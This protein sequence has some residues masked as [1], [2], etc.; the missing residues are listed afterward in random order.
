MHR[1]PWAWL[2]WLVVLGAVS[3]PYWQPRAPALLC[4]S[5]ALCGIAAIGHRA[6]P[7]WLALAVAGFLL[8]AA[9]PAMLPPPITGEHLQGEIISVSNRRTVLRTDNGEAELWFSDTVPPVGS[10]VAVWTASATPW[11]VLPGA[12]DST[13]ALRRA[14]RHRMRAR[15]WMLLGTPTASSN[16]QRTAAWFQHVRHGALLWALIRGKREDIPMETVELLRRTGTAHL[17]AISGMHIGWVSGLAWW[18]AWLLS[19]PL[20]L[21]RWAKPGQFVPILAGTAA[22]WMYGQAVGWPISTQRAVW[23][24]TALA[25]ARLLGRRVSLWNVLGMTAAGIALADPAQVGEIGFWMSFGAVA[26]MLSWSHALTRWLPPDHPGWLGRLLLGMAASLGATLGTLPMTAWLF[27]QL[28]PLTLFTNLI[29]GPL[30]AGVALP[31]ALLSCALPDTPARLALAVADAATQLTMTAL[32]AMDVDPLHP[33]VGPVGAMALAAVL[34]LR[35]HPGI[36]GLLLLLALGLRSHPRQLSVTFLAIGQ[37][38]AALVEWPDGT[39]WL[40]DGG[41]PS[42]RLLH[43]L[44][45]RGIRSLDAIILSHPHPDHMGGLQPIVDAMP[46][47][48]LWV[49]RPPMPG[50]TQFRQLW[51]SAFAQ[52][53]TIR[54][55][56]DH[57]LLSRGELLHPLNGWTAQRRQDRVNEE[58]LVVQIT[59]GAHRFLFT[60][61][62][63][64]EAETLLVETLETVDVIKVPH[65]G[66]TSSSSEA[67][68]AATQAKWAVISCGERNRFR[69]PRPRTLHRWRDAQVLRTDTNGTIRFRSD[70]QTLTVESHL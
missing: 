39:R 6:R 45:R 55:P 1:F 25:G 56:V 20:T 23:M 67:L 5:A 17:L 35:R 52:H 50:E 58:S 28:S 4:G 31:A 3:W 70:G 69:H 64:A 63:E 21:L 48:E 18:T 65:H 54:T 10:R 42:S 46:V 40:I 14:H 59:H 62:I 33:A 43:H 61:D 7:G 47:T 16:E 19:R 8:G 34:P 13:P 11:V 37:G 15:Q 68:V 44:R 57:A 30:M 51:Y 26:G 32:S 53:T 24:V 2:G 38:D 12:W 49:P 9:R 60:G 66:S 36:A 41:P 22:A 29:A 27:Q